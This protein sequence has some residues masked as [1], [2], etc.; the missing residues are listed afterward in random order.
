MPSFAIYAI[1][2]LVLLG[3]LAYGAFLLNVPQQWILVG[4]LVMLGLG[5]TTGVVKTRQKD[6]PDQ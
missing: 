4:A 3:G 6:V 1:G 5:I 2:F